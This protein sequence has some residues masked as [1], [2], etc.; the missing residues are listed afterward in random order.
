[1]V[2]LADVFLV[3]TVTDGAMNLLRQIVSSDFSL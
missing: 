1:M 3:N 2:N